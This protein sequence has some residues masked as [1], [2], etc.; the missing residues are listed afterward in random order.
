MK[1]APT[2]S[3]ILL[4]TYHEGVYLCT[5]GYKFSNKEKVTMFVFTRGTFTTSADGTHYYQQRN[6]PF[7]NVYDIII[8]CPE[9]VDTYF[10]YCGAIDHH[11][12]QHQGHFRFEKK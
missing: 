12:N 1:E 9:V 4:I 6:D 5:F 10:M 8:K 3:H 7:K 2:Y 11:N